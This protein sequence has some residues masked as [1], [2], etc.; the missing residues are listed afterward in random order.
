MPASKIPATYFLI[1]IIQPPLSHCHEGNYNCK[2]KHAPPQ[3]FEAHADQLGNLLF[4]GST[5]DLA[6]G[7]I[8]LN[9]L[10]NGE[11]KNCQTGEFSS[12]WKRTVPTISICTS[13]F[14]TLTVPKTKEIIT[15]E[16][17]GFFTHL[18]SKR[19]FFKQNA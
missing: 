19:R 10:H 12:F 15:N 17:N 11:V 16:I 14:A 8:E 13:F 4:K 2:G 1:F 3:P 6:Q 5:Y 9:D 18:F 7:A